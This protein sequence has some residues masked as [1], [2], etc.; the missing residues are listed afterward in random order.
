[1]RIPITAPKTRRW[2]ILLA[3]RAS[4]PIGMSRSVERSLPLMQQSVV[5]LVLA[6]HKIGR[7]VVVLVQIDVMDDSL[8]RKWMP[9]CSLGNH[10]MVAHKS[11]SPLGFGDSQ[12]LT[13]ATA[14]PRGIGT[15][16]IVT[17]DESNWPTFNPTPAAI[18]LASQR[19][20]IAAATLTKDQS[21]AAKT[22]AST[23]AMKASI[24]SVSGL[25]TLSSFRVAFKCWRV[26]PS[27]S[28]HCC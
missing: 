26:M 8:R 4:E 7:R 25:L 9:Q 23:S 5:R 17:V 21:H 18:V 15:A 6:D 10:L 24:F 28:A 19:R 11:L 16:L 14:P 22:F 13:G 12:V 3:E 20:G 27:F 1:M 2:P